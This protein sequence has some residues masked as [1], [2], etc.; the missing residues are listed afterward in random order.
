[1]I[2]FRYGLLGILFLSFLSPAPAQEKLV[3]RVPLGEKRLVVIEIEGAAGTITLKKNPSE[4]LFVVTRVA[5]KRED[6]DPMAKVSYRESDG[7]GYLTVNL[8]EEGK[9]N[10]DALASLLSG[11]SGR[12]WNLLVSDRVP[13]ALSFKLGAGNAKLD[14]TGIR[15]QS[16]SIDAGAGSIR[17][18]VD[19]PNPEMAKHVSLSAGV[20]SI[21][22]RKLGNLRFQELDIEGGLGSYKLDCRGDL[23]DG[24]RIRTDIGL[25]S[26]MVLLPTE[27]GARAIA[28]KRWYN[29][30][31]LSRFIRDSDDSYSTPNYETAAKRVHLNLESG[32]GSVSVR[33]AD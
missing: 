3:S 13:V 26:M 17:V 23:R 28:Q 19:N 11:A 33:W 31:S 10:V 4:D 7:V 5:A 29:S 9:K 18:Y 32:L 25:G 22:S 2:M 1:M 27:V 8:G 15:M 30:T 6:S 20:G 14:L 24:A 12:T 21:E 16:L